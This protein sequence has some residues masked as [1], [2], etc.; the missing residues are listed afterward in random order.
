MEAE[1]HYLKRN[2]R[3]YFLLLIEVIY[4]KI[5]IHSLTPLTKF[6]QVSEQC[7]DPNTGKTEMSKTW[8]CCT[9]N[10]WR[11]TRLT[12]Q[13]GRCV[14]Y[15]VRKERWGRRGDQQQRLGPNMALAQTLIHLFVRRLPPST[16]PFRKCEEGKR[17]QCGEKSVVAA[18]L[19]FVT[20]QIWNK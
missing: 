1:W 13:G 6:R 10:Q 2:C 16:T 9:Q 17:G 19:I 11:E 3:T 12:R 8:H 15:R 7:L 20:R 18:L 14:A 4:K 5:I